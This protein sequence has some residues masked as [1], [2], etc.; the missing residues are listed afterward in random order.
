MDKCVRSGDL[1]DFVERVNAEQM[2]AEQV[3]NCNPQ[4]N[5]RVCKGHESDGLQIIY[6]LKDRKTP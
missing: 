1:Y 3:V 5:P 2:A 6:V 4:R